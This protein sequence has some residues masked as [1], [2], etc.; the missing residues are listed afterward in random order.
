MRFRN[1]VLSIAGV[2]A[3]GEPLAFAQSVGDTVVVTG[4]RTERLL[5]ESPV[6][7]EVIT[8]EQIEKRHARDL[9]EALQYLPGI[10]LREIHGKS[11]YEVWIQGLNADRVLVLI[12]GLPVSP[13]T[14]SSVDVTQLSL[15]D[16]ERVEVVKGA[17]SAQYGSAAMGGVVNIITRPIQQGTLASATFDTGTYGDQNP[18]GDA[19]VPSTHHGRA[20][21]AMGGE[22][23]RFRLSADENASDGIDPDPDSWP[24]PGNEV[25]RDTIDSRVE[26]YDSEGRGKGYLGVGW[27]GEESEARFLDDVNANNF[28]ERHRKDEDLDRL[29]LATGFSW[30][31]KNNIR[32]GFDALRED[33]SDDT[34]KY[35]VSDGYQYDNRES[36]YR[37]ERFNTRIELPEFNQHNLMIGIDGSRE[38]LDQFK[39]GVSELQVEEGNLTKAQ[40]KG[41]EYFLQ[42]D[43][44]VLDD[45]EVLLGVRYQEDSDFGSHVSPKINLRYQVFEQSDSDLFVRLG[46]GTGY[47]VPNLKERHYVFDHSQL[48]YMVLGNPN[49]VPEE[50]DSWQLGLGAR[51]NQSLTVDLN[52]FYNK[53]KDLIQTDFSDF[54]NSIAIY[55]YSN[56]SRA[57]TQGF[58][59][60]SQWIASAQWQFNV[61]YTFLQA[62]NL[63]TG[64]DLTRRP[65]HQITAGAQWQPTLNT[66]LS[67]FVRGQSDELA[68]SA[69]GI[70]SPGWVVCDIK[71][72]HYV[73]DQLRVFG[74]LDNVFDRQ[75][76]FNSGFDFAPVAGRYFYVGVRWQ[77]DQPALN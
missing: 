26:W 47:R 74:G 72:N 64:G 39:D 46:W 57:K 38:T 24:Q 51:F 4:T 50:S 60:S 70:R 45:W 28:Y 5:R 6:Y 56:V 16:V 8:S 20:S 65:E 40:R 71:V 23:W 22:R 33:Q 52:V 9:K 73:S 69:S 75:R 63:D 21:V 48:G 53:L 36:D 11:G 67:A 58:E 17:T 61:G 35:N 3:L 34:Q 42:D 32:W 66:G 37:I 43:W 41:P 18:S 62:E 15:L 76:D 68:D 1:Y 29:R 59:I 44:F 55:S 49:L 30:Q 7:T 27:F 10:Q 31:H 77:W 14:G 25:K 54:Q 19:W 2:M 13:T 12:D